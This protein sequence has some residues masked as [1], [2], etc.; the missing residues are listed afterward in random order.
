MPAEP[1]RPA[2]QTH[3]RRSVCSAERLTSHRL[4]R[5]TGPAVC[6]RC[7]PPRRATNS[8]S[9]R[10]SLQPR[11]HA[12]RVAPNRAFDDATTPS[13]PSRYEL[14]AKGELFAMS[15]PFSGVLVPGRR[16][17]RAPWTIL[18]GRFSKKRPFRTPTTPLSAERDRNCRAL[19]SFG[20]LL[21]R[22]GVGSGGPI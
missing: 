11:E 1:L 12:L 10:A 17:D 14:A 18:R 16:R 7:I 19:S 22:C 2:G 15:S 21:G 13:P 4:D 20:T 8:R 9:K 5:V 6:R 3:S